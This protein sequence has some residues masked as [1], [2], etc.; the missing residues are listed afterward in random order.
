MTPE[1][2]FNRDI[3]WILQ[4]IRNEELLTPEGKYIKFDM[5]VLDH[6]DKSKKL[7]PETPD[8]KTQKKLLSK[9]DEWG[10][11]NFKSEEDPSFEVDTF[12]PA[13]FAL[14]LKKPEFDILYD[15]Y[16]GLQS[17]IP[18]KSTLTSHKV[19]SILL[20]T[21]EHHN[22]DFFWVILNHDYEHKNKMH[23]KSKHSG[24]ND[25]IG[26][27]LWQLYQEKQ[28]DFDRGFLD[29]MNNKI[30]NLKSFEKF[31]KT[32]LLKM[33]KNKL[34]VENGISLERQTRP[35]LETSIMKYFA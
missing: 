35:L 31:E 6:Y 22:F 23:L 11:F 34:K 2:K 24:R 26:S 28:V 5:R 4:E 10:V 13:F 18:S 3:W 27:K 25:G 33:S 21:P 14:S 1:E 29:Y 32:K 9:L 8:E 7:P 20:V 19:N 12:D 16:E 30:F 17:I 15:K